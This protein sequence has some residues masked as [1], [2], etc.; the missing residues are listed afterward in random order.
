[1]SAGA[2]WERGKAL[3]RLI[4]MLYT[5]DQ[6][7]AVDRQ[8]NDILSFHIADF[9]A[10]RSLEEQM[11]GLARDCYIQGLLDGHSPEVRA[12]MASTPKGSKHE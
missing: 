5:A 6:I 10:H 11:L 7:D 9:T 2:S 12:A 4:P 1:M 8:T 3:K